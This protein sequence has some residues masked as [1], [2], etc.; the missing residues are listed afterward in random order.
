MNA[1]EVILLFCSLSGIIGLGINIL[2]YRTKYK[3]HKRSRAN[4]FTWL[5]DMGLTLVVNALLNGIL[6]HDVDTSS[7]GGAIGFGLSMIFFVTPFFTIIVPSFWALIRAI[8]IKVTPSKE[9]DIAQKT[10]EPTLG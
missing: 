4:T 5:W 3:N 2:F 1:Q 9:R 8:Y 7:F 6:L 10:P